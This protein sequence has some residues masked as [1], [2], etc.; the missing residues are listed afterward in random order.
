MRRLVGLA[1]AGAALLFCNGCTRSSAAESRSATPRVS[2]AN[3]IEAGRYLVTVGGCNDCH[4]PNWSE[5]NGGVPEKEWLTGSPVGWRGP[6]GTTYPSNLRLIASAF[7]ED[8]WVRML[9][10]RRDRPPMPWPNVNR[11]HEEDARAVYRFIRSLGPAGDPAPGALAPDVEP[12]TAFIRMAPPEG[13]AAPF[14]TN[15]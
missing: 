13:P 10:T 14:A 7:S 8:D 12:A 3:P 5:T 15:H 2:A 4:T 6:W 11:M 1:A 9:H